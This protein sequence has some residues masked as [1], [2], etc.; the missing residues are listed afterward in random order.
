MLLWDL[1]TATQSLC[2]I[3]MTPP[4]KIGV[5]HPSKMR[6]AM[7]AQRKR[8]VAHPIP[9]LVRLSMQ[10]ESDSVSSSH[11]WLYASTIFPMSFEL[12]NLSV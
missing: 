8:I 2:P 6:P 9:P 4:T 1:Q 5:A 12:W 11:L 10:C 3:G 7:L